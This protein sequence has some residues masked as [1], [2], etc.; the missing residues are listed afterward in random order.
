LALRRGEIWEGEWQINQFD[1][2][3]PEL[4]RIFPLTERH[5]QKEK[6]PIDPFPFSRSKPIESSMPIPPPEH[7][8]YRS[9]SVGHCRKKSR[10]FDS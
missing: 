4:D 3:M 9:I 8:A 5:W 7:A 2:A 1:P 10:E 6:R